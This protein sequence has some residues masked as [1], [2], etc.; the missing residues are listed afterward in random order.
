MVNLHFGIG[1]GITRC[2]YQGKEVMAERVG[3]DTGTPQF[4]QYYGLNPSLT[5]GYD[6]HQ[7]AGL[8]HS[9]PQI[10]PKLVRNRTA[11]KRCY[12][13]EA[14]IGKAFRV[15]KRLQQITLQMQMGFPCPKRPSKKHRPASSRWR[16]PDSPLSQTYHQECLE[17]FGQSRW[18]TPSRQTGRPPPSQ[19]SK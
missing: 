7:D 19:S 10:A 16:L 3:W 14:P 15:L 18:S 11:K 17:I 8:G 12:R 4:C 13:E 9:E 1:V 5:W 6:F 2:D